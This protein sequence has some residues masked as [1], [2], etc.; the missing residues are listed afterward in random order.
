MAEQMFK[1]E[2]STISVIN[3]SNDIWFRGKTIAKILGYKHTKA[4]I[5]SHVDS[6]DKSKLG[7]LELGDSRPLTHNEK[8]TIYINKSGLRSLICRSRMPNASALAKEFD[9][10]IH[11]HKYECKEAESLG[12]I[13]K[14]FKGEKMKTQHPVLGYRIDLY[15]PDYNLAI[16]C[17]ENGHSDRSIAEEIQR[18]RRITK[19]IKCQWL[20]FNPDSTDFNIFDVINQ[21]FTIIKTN[22]S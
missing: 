19:K 10:D 21:I 18:Q 7:D 11:S 12:A 8:T 14:V 22:L 16:E 17:D 5:G 3:N 6:E 15:F 4:A 9:I 2:K 20:R 13:M 1:F